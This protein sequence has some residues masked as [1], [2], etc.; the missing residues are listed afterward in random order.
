MPLN[1]GGELLKWPLKGLGAAQIVLG[2]PEM[3]RNVMP[4][5]TGNMLTAL[6]DSGFQYLMA[7]ARCNIGIRSGRYLFEACLEPFL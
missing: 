7:A 1:I 2:E 4:S 5:S 3:V 6:S